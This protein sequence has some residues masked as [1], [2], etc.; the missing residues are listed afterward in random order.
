MRIDGW[1][2][3][4]DEANSRFLHFSS[5][6]KNGKIGSKMEATNSYQALTSSMEQSLS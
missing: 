3:G 6:P 1:T 5:A 2:D 4:H